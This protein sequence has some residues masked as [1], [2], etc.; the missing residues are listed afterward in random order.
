[1]EIQEKIQNRECYGIVLQLSPP[2][3]WRFML[4]SSFLVFLSKMI[5]QIPLQDA[6][7]SSF[8]SVY[9]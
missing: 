1:M 4:D 3:F 6:V 9:A 2:Y 7:F 8:P 5:L